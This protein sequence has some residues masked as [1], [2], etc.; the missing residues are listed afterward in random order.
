MITVRAIFSGR[1]ERGV[2][3]RG[4]G[5]NVALLRFEVSKDQ[6]KYKK[7]KNIYL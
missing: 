2:R 6:I 4:A 7:Q 5:I 1:D 3:E